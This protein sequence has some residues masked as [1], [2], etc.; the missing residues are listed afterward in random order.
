M[1]RR[2]LE[3]VLS[4]NLQQY[5]NIASLGVKGAV[6]EFADWLAELLLLVGSRPYESNEMIIRDTRE[7]LVIP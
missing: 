5:F 3:N 7:A 1:L 6:V 2:N 4:L